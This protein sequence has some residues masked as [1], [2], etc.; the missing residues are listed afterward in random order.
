[1]HE[2][3]LARGERRF[4]LKALQGALMISLYSS[5]PRFHIPHELLKALMDIDSLVTKWRCKNLNLIISYISVDYLQS[6]LSRTFIVTP[7]FFRQPCHPCST[8]AGISTDGIWRILW[9][10]ILEINIKWQIQNISWSFQSF[11]ILDSKTGY[12]SIDEGNEAQA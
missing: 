4:S 8:Y 3:L 6:N 9:L 2:A 12:S 11:N 1:M 7:L 5:E 10:S